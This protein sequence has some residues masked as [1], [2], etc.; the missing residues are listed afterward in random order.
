MIFT[1]EGFL[2]SAIILYIFE[3]IFNYFAKKKHPII[4]SID[5]NIGSGKSTL[6]K[7]LNLLYDNIEYVKEPVDDWTQIKDSNGKNILDKFYSQ[8]ERWA[9]TFQNMAYITRTINIV[10]GFK[11]AINKNKK[12]VIT[13][14]CTETDKNVFAKMLYEQ[15]KSISDLEYDIYNLWC[16]RM[17]YKVKN[18]IYLRTTPEKSFERIKKR[19]RNE[20]S[21]ITLDYIKKIHQYHEKWLNNSKATK[22]NV[23]I[24]DVTEEFENN[25]K[26]RNEIVKTIIKFINNCD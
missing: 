22:Y 21:T 20:E 18:I 1:I 17:D 25:I 5:G 7:I 19:S 4:I 12:Y 9:Y 15:D 23:C 24:I 10:D 3:Y 2:G 8:R 13:E 11:N 6:V 14:R 26:R 16:N